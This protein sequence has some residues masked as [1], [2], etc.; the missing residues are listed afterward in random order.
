MKILAKIDRETF[1]FISYE[2]VDNIPYNIPYKYKYIGR[3]VFDSDNKDNKS[4]EK[5]YYYYFDIEVFVSYN[6]SKITSD[7]LKILRKEKLK[8]IG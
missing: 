1:D 7:L 6:A 5:V 3:Y 4:Q 2:V 8:I